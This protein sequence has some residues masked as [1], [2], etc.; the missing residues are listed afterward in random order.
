MDY[1]EKFLD[2]SYLETRIR[3]FKEIKNGDFEFCVERSKNYPES[4]S[5]YVHFKRGAW[6]IAE[7]RVSDHSVNTAQTQFIVERGVI[8]GKKKKEQ[9]VRLVEKVIGVAKKKILAQALYKI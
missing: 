4:A 3:D 2:K 6:N 8:L 9:F 1:E 5:L 7:L